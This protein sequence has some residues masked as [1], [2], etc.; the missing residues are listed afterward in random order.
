MLS[1]KH[2]CS[3]PFRL[4]YKEPVHVFRAIS[5]CL[6]GANACLL[7]SMLAQSHFSCLQGANAG[8]LTGMFAQ[9]HFLF[10]TWNLDILSTKDACSGVS[11]RQR[12]TKAC[13]PANILF[14]VISPPSRR[15]GL[16]APCRH[17]VVIFNGGRY[18]AV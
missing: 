5:S 1:V 11:P 17:F 6:Q 16:I 2:T 14:R 12:R 10:P 15:V 13:V 3:E 7:P 9:N 4:A 8:L 18:A